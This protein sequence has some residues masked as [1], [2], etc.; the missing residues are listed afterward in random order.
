MSFPP[1]LIASL[2][3]I[4]LAILLGT[5]YYPGFSGPFLLDDFQII[6][7]S[8]LSNFSWSE[9]LSI[10][11][12]SESGPLNRPIAL[13]SFAL[14]SFWLGESPFYYKVV[15]LLLHLLTGVA[16]FAVLKKLCSIQQ[17]RI[18]NETMIV[19]LTVILWLFHPLHIS[20][21]LYTVQ[22]MTILS[23]LFMLLGLFCYLKGRDSTDANSTNPHLASRAT[24]THKWE[25]GSLLWIGACFLIF[26]PLSVLSKE[27]GALLPLYVLTL[28]LFCIPAKASRG[29]KWIWIILGML[30]LAV[31]IGYVLLTFSQ[32]DNAY[33]LNN[34][35]PLSRL[36]T[37][38]SV[39]IFYAKL[40]FFPQLSDMG[41]NQ[42]DF[43]ILSLQAPGAWLNLLILVFIVYFIIYF[44]KHSPIICFGLAWFLISHIIESTILP[45]ELVFEHRNYLAMVGLI[46]IPVYIVFSKLERLKPF[47]KK[48]ALITFS[49]LIINYAVLTSSRSKIW[50]SETLYYANALLNH[51][52][53][54]RAHLDWA[55]VLLAHGYHQE[56]FIELEHAERLAPH[57]SSA[58]IQ[59]LLVFCNQ[60]QRPDAIYNKALWAAKNQPLSSHA[61]N[62]LDLL[63]QNALKKQCDSIPAIQIHELLLAALENPKL[64]SNKN[65]YSLV[66]QLH[67][68][69]LYLL[70]DY[71]QSIAYFEQAYLVHPRRLDPLFEKLVIQIKLG[72]RAD[73]ESTLNALEAIML[74]RPYLRVKL[75]PF[76]I[77]VEKLKLQNHA[78]PSANTL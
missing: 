13:A 22:R 52:R 60:S 53:S 49:L 30:P 48:I 55:N 51:P 69:I 18:P 8:Q 47:Y 21:V 76:Y 67:A 17:P 66:L 36:M 16:L 46:I 73:S 57:Q 15:N 63:T 78:Q 75:K 64:E 28:E 7:K 14:N 24:L 2:G 42:D 70:E 38:I 35:T 23:S 41:L 50:S 56:G 5:C 29:L 39:L 65:W 1:K 77:E 58:T 74:D 3:G 44:R 10:S 27:N 34:I 62:A 12:G 40:I 6:P 54:A 25:R 45:L 61:L 31:G 72:R 26:F 43:A 68:R 11:L 32:F 37:E 9:L 4:A 71:T 59:K 20:T 19:W 33:A